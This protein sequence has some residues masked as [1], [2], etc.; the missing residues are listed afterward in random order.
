[1]DTPVESAP[2]QRKREEWRSFVFLAVVMVP[3]FTGML[4]IAY[5]FLIWATQMVLGQ[6]GS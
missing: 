3:A 2:A 1:M 5:G 4:I 6:P